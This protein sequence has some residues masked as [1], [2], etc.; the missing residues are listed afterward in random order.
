MAADHPLL[1]RVL[2]IVAQALHEH[3]P[4]HPY[5]FGNTVSLPVPEIGAAGFLLRDT[6]DFSFGE[7]ATVSR[8][9]LVPIT[10]AEIERCRRE[11]SAGL[12]AELGHIGIDTRAPRW[13]IRSA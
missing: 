5:H 7:G 2:G 4:E 12:V 10:Q 9:E 3:P 6:G 13:A 1:A 11:G 8:M